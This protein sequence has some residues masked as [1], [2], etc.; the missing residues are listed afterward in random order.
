MSEFDA[1][2]VLDNI[3][4]IPSDGSNIKTE[5][6]QE[7]IYTDVAL[8]VG[9]TSF[10]DKAEAIRKDLGDSG[11][12]IEFVESSTEPESSSGGFSNESEGDLKTIISEA[13]SAQSDESSNTEQMVSKTKSDV[14]ISI[15]RADGQDSGEVRPERELDISMEKSSLDND[16]W[17]LDPPSTKYEKFYE[18][19]REN[20]KKF[21]R[22]GVIPF[23]KYTEELNNAKVDTRVELY[24]HET[25]YDKMTEIRQWKDRVIQI[26]GHVLSQYFG[27]KRFVVLMHGVLARVEYEKPVIRQEGLN[28]THLR[29]L[30]IYL[31]EL[32]YLY[33]YTGDIIKNLDSGYESMSRQ[34]AMTMPQKA[35]DKAANYSKTPSS[36]SDTQPEKSFSSRRDLSDFDTLEKG[37]KPKDFNKEKSKDN[38]SKNTDISWVDID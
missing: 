13:I 14:D 27:W 12:D 29:D 25:I 35:L 10:D 30:E 1:V 32:E 31:T 2:E 3:F 36:D 11:E 21:L 24:D 34:V 16:R 7:S 5:E 9:N 22:G 19:K 8:E 33:E 6:S 23:D 4:N 20:L 18:D 37:V 28:F 15:G 26:R 17:F 38:T